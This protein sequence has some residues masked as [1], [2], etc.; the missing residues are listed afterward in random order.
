[1]ATTC[2]QQ[3]QGLVLVKKYIGVRGTLHVVNAEDLPGD[4]G[5]HD[6]LFQGNKVFSGLQK[7]P[8]CT[9]KQIPASVALY[10][11]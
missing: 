1:M 4:L 5:E 11:I 8:Y 6:H 9:Q 7:G 2:L 3:V 10:L